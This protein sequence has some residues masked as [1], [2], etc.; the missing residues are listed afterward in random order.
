MSR[1]LPRRSIDAPAL[2]FLPRLASLVRPTRLILATVAIGALAATALADPPDDDEPPD[3]GPI[4]DEPQSPDDPSAPTTPTI[5]KAEARRFLAAGDTLIKK[6]DRLTRR[7]RT[8]EAGDHYERAL[9][10]YQR[11][12][13][14]SQNEHVYYPIAIAE[15]RLGKTVDAI[16]HYR[17]VIAATGFPAKTLA[18]AQKRLDAL[19]MTVG[20]VTIAVEPAGAA[21]VLDGHP[22]G[23]AP[24]PEPLIIEPGVYVL[25]LTA[26]GF[27][28]A[29]VK[30]TIEPGSESERTFKLEAVPVVVEKPKVA[31]PPPPP[32]APPPPSRTLL[33]VG[34]GGTIALVA[35]AS[36]TGSLA[37]GK[38][39]D[40][41]D[42]SL[43][44]TE[45]D[46]AASSGKSLALVT[47][48]C[49]VGAAA[50]A[51]V[52]TY[53]YFKIYRPKA[54]DRERKQKAVDAFHD[55][56]SKVR[57]VPWVQPASAGLSVTGVLPF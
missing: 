10:S 5:D 29:E 35:I 8:V 37:L 13:D 45:R 28:P 14:L 12:F 44:E 18:D 26:D 43:S 56:F 11:A 41:E 7:K 55:E 4:E 17:I 22:I 2:R 3:I 57:V 48:V 46:D 49:L 15:E 6:G 9:L 32:P 47:D 53:Y 31:P 27:E 54:R 21:I 25:S 30:L 19:L 36:L 23:K 16:K 51:A 50:T 20:Q 52:T 39:S 42:T 1:G 38:Q 34:A 24:L 40:F 33:W